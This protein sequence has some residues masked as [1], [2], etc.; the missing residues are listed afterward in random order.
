M[1]RSDLVSRALRSLA[2]G[3]GTLP[4]PQWEDALSSLFEDAPGEIFA[5]YVL[6]EQGRQLSETVRAGAESARATDPLSGPAEPGADH[7]M[8]DYVLGLT[9]LDQQMYWSDPYRAVATGTLC[10]T[11]S[12]R[13]AGSTGGGILCADV[14]G[15]PES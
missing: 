14:A 7:S 11:V 4:V 12:C 8:K 2:E 9:A 6:D 10:R 5:A 13:F 1:R 15:T 3:L